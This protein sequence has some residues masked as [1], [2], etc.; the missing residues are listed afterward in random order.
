[1]ATGLDYIHAVA[2][3]MMLYRTSPEYCDATYTKGQIRRFR[4]F[5]ESLYADGVISASKYNTLAETAFGEDN[6]TL[7]PVLCNASYKELAKLIDSGAI[8]Y[9]D[10]KDA[11]DDSLW[12]DAIDYD[13][14]YWPL[15]NKAKHLRKEKEGRA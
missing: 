11:I 2:I 10:A 14:D 8:S 5:L 15:I 6:C 3:D 1:M 12:N 4:D 13:T 7:K 9:K